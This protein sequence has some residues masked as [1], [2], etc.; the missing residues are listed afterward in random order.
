[1]TFKL[2]FFWKVT[3]EKNI[4]KLIIGVHSVYSYA[5]P[6]RIAINKRYSNLLC[7]IFENLAKLI[8]K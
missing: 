2:Y 7:Q 3:S 6:L 1:M 8:V 5:I 4:K